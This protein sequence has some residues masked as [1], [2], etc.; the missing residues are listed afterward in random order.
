ME[1]FNFLSELTRACKIWSKK[2]IFSDQVHV[3]LLDFFNNIIKLYFQLIPC[4]LHLTFVLHTL[5]LSLMSYKP[6]EKLYFHDQKG[7]EFL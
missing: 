3:I 4:Y 5:E 2:S 6:K 1:V 7:L